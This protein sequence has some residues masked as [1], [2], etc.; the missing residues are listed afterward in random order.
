MDCR[1]LL[2]LALF[3]GAGCASTLPVQPAGTEA[4]IPADDRPHKPSTYAAF[5]DYRTSAGFARGVDE[6]AKAA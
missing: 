4:A 1:K 5:A 2:L 6:S 3:A